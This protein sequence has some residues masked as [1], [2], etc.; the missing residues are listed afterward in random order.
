L[1]N[2]SANG[3]EERHSSLAAEIRVRCKIVEEQRVD[4]A[5]QFSVSLDPDQQ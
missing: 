3:A 4:A 1:P 2:W 5:D